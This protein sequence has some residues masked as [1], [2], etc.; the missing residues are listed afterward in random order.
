[1]H[2]PKMRLENVLPIYNRSTMSKTKG[3]DVD[4]HLPNG[5][6]VRKH[7]HKLSDLKEYVDIY[8]IPS[9][10]IHTTGDKWYGERRTIEELTKW[11]LVPQ[12]LDNTEDE[13][14]LCAAQLEHEHNKQ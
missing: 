6:D 7:I 2:M 4:L 9:V 14:P 12:K 10:T 13:C 11:P 8:N 3:F 5:Q 1:M